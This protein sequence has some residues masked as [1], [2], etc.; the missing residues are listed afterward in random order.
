MWPSHGRYCSC[1]STS[2]CPSIS[3]AKKTWFYS[4]IR[5]SWASRGKLWLVYISHN[6]VI[7]VWIIDLGTDVSEWLS[8]NYHGKSVGDFWERP[9]P[10]VALRGQCSKAILYMCWDWSCCNHFATLQR[11]AWE[12]KSTGWLSKNENCLWWCWS[13]KWTT[14]KL[15]VLGNT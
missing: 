9:P 13:T 8:M 4:R 10:Y 7:L 14:S 15:P 3:F 2:H 1:L 11:Q 5:H 12:Q 6:L